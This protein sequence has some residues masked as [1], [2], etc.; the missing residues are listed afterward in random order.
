MLMLVYDVTAEAAFDLLRWRSQETQVKLRPFAERVAAEFQALSRGHRLPP[1]SAYDN[2]LLSAHQRIT[3]WAQPQAAKRRY[4]EDF[5][6]V[7]PSG[8]RTPMIPNGVHRPARD[9]RSA[10]YPMCALRTRIWLGDIR[11]APRLR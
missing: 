10:R 6:R 7:M 8:G 1:R 2:V 4:R 11:C 9:G 5:R 3:P